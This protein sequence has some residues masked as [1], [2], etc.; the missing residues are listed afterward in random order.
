MPLS[1]TNTLVTP[2][3][4]FVN[5]IITPQRV[6]S[7]RETRS[8]SNLGKKPKGKKPVRKT[9]DFKQQASIKTIRQHS[10]LSTSR[11]LTPNL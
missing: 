6:D 8:N 10:I 7:G 1:L 4:G 5:G 11:S 2:F 3:N 9:S